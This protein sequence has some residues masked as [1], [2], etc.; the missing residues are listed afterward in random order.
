MKWVLNTRD[1]QQPVRC[2]SAGHIEAWGKFLKEKLRKKKIIR[3][4]A[5]GAPAAF[6][7]AVSLD[8]DT[9]LTKKNQEIIQNAF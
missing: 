2:W 7:S 3:T 4:I 8:V 5:S 9:L 1:S 6:I